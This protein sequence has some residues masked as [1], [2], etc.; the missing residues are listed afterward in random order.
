MPE[1]RECYQHFRTVEYIF[2]QNPAVDKDDWQ[3]EQLHADL[4]MAEAQQDYW[5]KNGVRSQE[6]GVEPLRANC[7]LERGCGLVDQ[8]HDEH[9][10]RG[11]NGRWPLW[12]PQLQS[13]DNS[14]KVAK[15][16]LSCLTLRRFDWTPRTLILDLGSLMMQVRPT[17]S[18]CLRQTTMF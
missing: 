4:T 9:N 13:T 17:C 7:P 1:Y 5:E 15:E 10:P 3:V 2:Q 14:C 12:P 11:E 6:G 8:E 16:K 18:Q